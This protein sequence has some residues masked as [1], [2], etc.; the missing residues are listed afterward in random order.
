MTLLTRSERLLSRLTSSSMR[1]SLRMAS[2]LILFTYIGAHLLNH[3]LGL[4][5]L[6]A[7]EAG[8]GLA[9]EVWYSW[10]GTVLLYGAAAFHFVLALW[11]V[12]ERRTL[13]LPLAEII[14]IAMGF[15]LPILLIGHAANT[16][17][18]YEILG[19]PSDYTRVVFELQASGSQGWQLGLMA[20]GWIHG[21]L[22]L[23]FAFSRRRLFQ[24]FRVVLF[25][26]ALLLPVFSGVGFIVMGRE[27]ALNPSA[28][29][30][31]EEFRSPSAAAKRLVIAQWKE[32][33]VFWYFSLIAAAFIARAARNLLEVSSKR[34]IRVS[35]PG[36]SVSVPRGW[37]VLEASRGFHIPHASMCGG[38]ARCSTCR[39]Q[40]I[41]GE[42]F[43][44]PA[45]AD[46]RTTLERIGAP[47][48]VRLACQLRPQG[49]ISTVPLVGAMP[50]TSRTARPPL[51]GERNIVLLF[52]DFHS[53]SDLTR[54]QPPQDL[55]YV[56]KIYVEGIGAA[57]RRCG[58]ILS[59]VEFNGIRAFF[60]LDG[61][62]APAAK[63][64]LEA[65]G[66]IQ[67]VIS[68]LDNRL[69]RQHHGALK[70]AVS[71]HTGQAALAEIGLSSSPSVLAA[72][73][74][75]DTADELRKV[76]IAQ[77]KLFAISEP[78]LDAAGV[79]HVLEDRVMVRSLE[80][81][82]FTPVL[83]TDQAPF[84][85]KGEAPNGR[86]SPRLSLRRLWKE[87]SQ[88]TSRSGES[89]VA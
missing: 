45:E 44:P 34:L 10:P 75:L 36:R 15:S 9:V 54:G 24:K 76:A 16:R 82:P 60:G 4:I 20:P 26:I 2:G 32:G 56:R 80:S 66:A 72:G 23:Y 27:L 31:M 48:D 47:P 61:P 88:S 14:R 38:R 73:E 74:A 70:I 3:S 71:I 8:M 5:S 68:D 51:S 11:A 58:G 40:V 25:S 35:Y 33:L 30:A 55:L 57:I 78:V 21:C 50:P 13:R 67:G 52:C 1:R 42:E 43:C 46:E 7:A 37:S 77:E 87:R 79:N 49:D 89:N 64:A 62:I 29:K 81:G 28:A 83:L 18:A 69:G 19:M 22:G 86:Q 84:T 65:A 6:D 53:P 63:R 12:Y 85:S 39:I 41:A 59:Y 17:L